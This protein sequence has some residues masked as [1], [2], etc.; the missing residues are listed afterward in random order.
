MQDVHHCVHLDL[1]LSN[2]MITA[3]DDEDIFIESEDGQ[4]SLNGNLSIKLIDFGVA[5][6]YPS[7]TNDF[8]CDQQCLSLDQCQSQSPNQLNGQMYDAK[9]HDMWCLGHILFELMTGSKLYS[10]EDVFDLEDPDGGYRAL[11]NGT[12]PQYLKSIGVLKHFMMRS[13]SV[14]RGLLA[15]EEEQRWTAGKVIQELLPEVWRF[16][17]PEN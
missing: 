17:Q 12:L 2:I 8:R 1:N 3:D 5:E 4:I 15:V 11:C 10:A 9:K 7:G 6:I 14:L 16:A 13:F